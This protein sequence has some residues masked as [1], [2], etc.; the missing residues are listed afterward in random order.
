MLIRAH[1]TVIKYFTKTCL[2][3]KEIYIQK[4]SRVL[5]MKVSV[6]TPYWL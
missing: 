1:A 6:T 5:W 3:Q 2:Q 4:L